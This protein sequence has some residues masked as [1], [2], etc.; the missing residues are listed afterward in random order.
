EVVHRTVVGD[1]DR[2]DS[3]EHGL[4]T[5][6]GVDDRQ[7]TVP[8]ADRS[9]DVK[10]LAIRPA[11]REDVGHAAQ[12]RAVDGRTVLPK[13]ACYPAHGRFTCPRP[14]AAAAASL[15]SR[16]RARAVPCWWWAPGAEA[17][18]AGRRAPSE[19]WR[20]RTA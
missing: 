9:T 10:A 2:A 4:S 16:Q 12:Q 19:E 6:D 3:R 18:A 11:V 20:R 15:P 17:R 1:G 13:D 8:E 5:P 14:V 7:A